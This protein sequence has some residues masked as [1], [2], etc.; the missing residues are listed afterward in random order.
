MSLGTTIRA[1]IDAK[2]Y[3][4]WW[5][6][7]F[8]G[9]TKTT[10]SNIINGR[11]AEPSV[12]VVAAIADVLHESVD[13]L[14]GRPMRSLLQHEETTLRN[15][16]EIILQRVIP[17]SADGGAATPPP[18]RRR[19]RRA[20]VGEPIVADSPRPRFTTDVIESPKREIPR[21]L[22]DRGVRRAFYIQGDAMTG[23]GMREGDLLYVRT[24]VA[25]SEANGRIVVCRVRGFECVRRLE[26][27]D[28]T[29]HLIGA[30]PDLPPVELTPDE[31][32][33]F[34]IIGIVVA[35][36]SDL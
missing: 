12:Y 19:G 16:A 18:P 11:T 6:A 31:A 24:D 5:V 4:D 30:N 8:A 1:A 13:A 27:R 3:K 32:N 14:L 10:L 35:Q 28:G 23:A 25:L 17:P 29:L 15:A 36:R 33:D 22:R 20:E 26:I 9:V 34:E 21:D 2:G 7:H